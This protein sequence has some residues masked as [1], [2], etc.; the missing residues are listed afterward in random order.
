MPNASEI[1]T[2]FDNNVVADLKR[3]L[4]KRQCLNTTNSYFI[5]L[6][7]LVQSAGILTTSI[8]ASNNDTN[9]VWI[10]V[11]LNLFA[12]LIHVYEKTNN[13][14]LKKLLNDIHRIKEGHYVDE[15]V[16]VDTSAQAATDDQ[17]LLTSSAMRTHEADASV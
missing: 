13:A 14:L 1:Q 3:F 8:A 4:A 6:F 10:G 2:I 12:T 16:L 15:G 5:Y 9:M 11:G 7:H 17:P